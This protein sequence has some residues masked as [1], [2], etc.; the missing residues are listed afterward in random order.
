[1]LLE[2]NIEQEKL[3][4]TYKYEPSH[5]KRLLI[6]YTN[7]KSS[8]KPT[9][10]HSLASAIAVHTQFKEA[11]EVSNIEPEIRSNGWLCRPI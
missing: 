2:N 3:M 6:T 9:H 11:E 7:T 5:E 4:Y 1:M 10:P 8:G